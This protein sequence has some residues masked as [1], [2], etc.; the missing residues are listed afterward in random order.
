MN[1]KLAHVIS[2]YGITSRRKA[3]EMIRQGRVQLNDNIIRNVA[4]R[5][6][7]IDIIKI[8]GQKIQKCEKKLWLFHKPIRVLTTHSKESDKLTVFDFFK[9]EYATFIGRLDY[10]SEGLLLLTNDVTYICKMQQYSRIYEVTLT[11]SPIKSFYKELANP[12]L[13]NIKL[14]PINC[15]KTKQTNLGFQ[16]TLE[17]FEGKNREIRQLCQKFEL[18][19]LKLKRIQHGPYKLNNLSVGKFIQT[20]P[21][22]DTHILRYE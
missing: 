17:L 21:L 9:H 6:S 2:S 3:E 22:S 18:K 20:T 12:Y 14:L 11:S 19:I 8:D 16:L 4:M 5:I 7:S 1:K 10:M 15:L 13:G